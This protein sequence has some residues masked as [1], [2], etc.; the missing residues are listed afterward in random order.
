M[1]NL[2]KTEM[3]CV[4]VTLSIYMM[5]KEIVYAVGSLKLFLFGLWF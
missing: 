1:S 5:R 4:A 2:T 3:V